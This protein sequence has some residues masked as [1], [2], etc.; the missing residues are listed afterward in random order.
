MLFKDISYLELWQ[1]LS[2]MGWNHLCNF[3]RRHIEEQSC[4]IILNLD[5]S[6]RRKCRL[7]VFLIWCPGSPFVQWSVSICAILLEGIMETILLN[8]FEFGSVVQEEMSFKRFLIWSMATLLFGG[9]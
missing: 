7:K 6:F 9:A 3:G 2:S 5:Q 8:Y 4:E 1:P